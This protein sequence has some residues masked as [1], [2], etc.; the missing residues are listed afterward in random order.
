MKDL[1]P[2]GIWNSTLIHPFLLEHDMNTHLQGRDGP[3]DIKE[4]SVAATINS[5][6]VLNNE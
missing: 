1:S 3:Q 5:T 6:A 2:E 4:G